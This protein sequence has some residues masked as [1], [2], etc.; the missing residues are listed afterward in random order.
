[1][2]IVNQKGYNKWKAEQKSGYGK[3]IFAYVEKWAN[4]ME[5]EIASGK[6][7]EDIAIRTSH[8]ADT[9]EITGA[10]FGLSINV[11]V[12]HWK[13]GKQISSIRSKLFLI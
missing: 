8:Q 6:S 11:L 3:R 9:F 2:Q 10:A 12:K 4:L 5:S 1:M 13:Y 7:I